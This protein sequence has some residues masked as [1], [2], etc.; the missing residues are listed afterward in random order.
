MPW[1]RQVVDVATELMPDGSWAYRDIVVTVPR[2]AGKT[3]L[4][5]PKNIH[6]ML[7][8][9][10]VQCWLTAQK[11]QDAR[12][13]WGDIAKR[14]RKSPLASLFE[15]RRSNGSEALTAPTGSTLRVFAPTEDALH[16]KANESVDVDEA[17]AF[18][19]AHGV[20]LEQA[21]LPTF[22]TT[23][24]QMWLVSTAGHGGSTWLRGWVERGR[25]A[26][27]SGVREGIAYFERSLDD[28]QSLIVT[29]GLADDASLAERAAAFDTVVA[30]HPANGY[31]LRR[32]VIEKQA[33]SPTMTADGFLRA[34]GNVWTSTVDRVIP[35]HL[36]LARKVPAWPAPAPG[37]VALGFDVA[38]DRSDAAILAAWRDRP[39][40]PMRYQVVEARP[41]DEWLVR[42]LLELR[43][44]WRPIAIGHDD[45][46]AARDIGDEL[47]RGGVDL[48][49][50]T[51]RDLAAACAGFLSAVR[52]GRMEHLGQPALDDAVEV[53]ATRPVL[54]GWAWSRRTSAGSIAALTAATVAGWA[55]DHRPP[56]A[57]KPVFISRR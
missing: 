32:D 39:T 50:T 13:I 44:R 1:Q 54:D 37:S 29:T 55:F 2:Q 6:R 22:T 3:T 26:V 28:A 20:E 40:G 18:D 42:R 57:E 30:N 35:E 41:G 16:G 8:R 48:V 12:D 45:S 46:G 14:V 34:Y 27:D 53:A 51:S 33:A 43:D 19:A 47:R 52:N 25:E 23:G 5:G 11:R 9:E 31:T 17:W 10:D 7:T 15:V 24:G 4:L 49:A 36:W 56:P 38:I 21:I